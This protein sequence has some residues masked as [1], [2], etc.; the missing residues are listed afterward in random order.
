MR[1]LHIGSASVFQTERVSSILTTCSMMID[2]RK[3]RR[4]E[5]WYK[6]REGLLVKKKAYNKKVREAV[7]LHY[8]VN[9][10]IAC[11]CCSETAL[12]FL[13][14]DHIEGGGTQHRKNMG[15]RNL[16]P[17]LYREKPVGYRILCHNCNQAFGFYGYCP[18]KKLGS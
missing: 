12:E 10:K 7:L 15:S 11:E 17:Y 8:A 18:H 6:N 13:S 5:Y 1:V 9:G 14:M 3:K 4:R 16:Y 2:E